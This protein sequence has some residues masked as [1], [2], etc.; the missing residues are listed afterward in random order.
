MPSTARDSGYCWADRRDDACSF[1]RS[2]E[3]LGYI[4]ATGTRLVKVRLA[5]N[6]V[7]LCEFLQAEPDS[8]HPEHRFQYHLL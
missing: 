2:L 8:P 4:L 7:H 6:E 5:A 3:E 1:V